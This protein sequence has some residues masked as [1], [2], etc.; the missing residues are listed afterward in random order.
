MITVSLLGAG[1]RGL[2]TYAAVAQKEFDDVKFLCCIDK[3]QERLLQFQKRFGVSKEAL[4]KSAEEFF[5][6]PRLSDLLIIATHDTSHYELAKKALMK[7][8]D[9]IL[10]KPVALNVKELLELEELSNKLERT[11]IVC[12]V[13][14]YQKMWQMIKEIVDEGKLGRIVTIAHNENIGHYHYAHSYV[15]GSWRNKST[16]GPLVLTK[17]SHDIDL[18]YYLVGSQI[19]RVASF[20]TLS[21]FYSGNAP[22]GHGERCESCTV[23]KSCRY[24]GERMYTSFGGFFPLFT[25]NKYTRRAVKE[26]LRST[27][28]GRCIY[29]MDNNVVDNQSS[30]LEFENGV[31]ATFNLNAFT[32][33]MHRSIKVMCEYGE[34]RADERTIE[35][36]T[37][38]LQPLFRGFLKHL[39]HLDRKIIKRIRLYKPWDFS[40]YLGHIDADRIFVKSVFQN[41]RVKKQSLTPISESVHAHIAALALEEARVT[42][43]TVLIEEFIDKNR[44]K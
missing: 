10:E 31:S 42:G 32:R 9:L 13:L 3:D 39:L 11:V 23:R 20:G 43:E 6:K 7:G 33:R 36:S 2:D 28:Y 21:Y 14:R 16:S 40:K 27:D 22:K 26:G 4:Y 35:V 30:I 24:E 37:F 5:T 38:E 44:T 8:Y 41:Y 1:N 34:I 12:H 19:K 15:R 18:L 17:S 25:K 29:A